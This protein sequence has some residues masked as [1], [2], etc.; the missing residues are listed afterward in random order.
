MRYVIRDDEILYL[1]AEILSPVAQLH[2]KPKRWSHNWVKYYREVLDKACETLKDFGVE[3]VY[4][5]IHPENTKNIKT[6]RLFGFDEVQ[7]DEV[8][9]FTR[10]IDE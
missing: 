1:E 5:F 8:V 9:I 7:T 4:E 10:S 6:M 2:W 3:V